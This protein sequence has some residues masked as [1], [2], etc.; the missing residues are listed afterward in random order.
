MGEYKYMVLV[1]CITYNHAKYIKDAMNGFCMQETTF[2][3]VCT[4]IDDASTDGEPEVIEKYLEEHFDLA[5]GDVVRK[6]ETDNYVLTFAQHK[7]NKNCYFAVLYLK[8]NHYSIKKDKTPYFA[9]WLDSS[10]YI[11]I[12][13]GDDYWI[14]TMKLQKQVI[15]LEN[16]PDHT[17][18]IHA[19][20]RVE[21]RKDNVVITDIHKFNSDVEVVPDH[22]VLRGTGMFAA[23]SSMLYVGQAAN[24]YPEWAKHAPV[25]DR[26]MQ[27]ILFSRGSIGY[28]DDVMSVYRVGVPGSWTLRIHRKRKAN[29][30]SEK[31]FIQMYKDF[32]EWSNLEYHS[33]II[34]GIRD[35]KR[36]I[37]KNRIIGFLRVSFSFIKN[38]RSQ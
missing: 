18:C 38:K 26:P 33:L 11:A 24:D 28:L 25:G 14:D 19:Y 4:I 3:F 31:Q 6:E 34:K 8:Y 32:D 7:T 20:Q 5:N 16:H 9:E 27:L 10:K 15:F 12:C 22:E 35:F 37:I 29:K 36:R 21:Y 13:E 30:Q 2:P 23:T 17:L 1:K